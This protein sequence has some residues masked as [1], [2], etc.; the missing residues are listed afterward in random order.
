MRDWTAIILAAGKGTRMVSETPKVLHRILG[1]SLIS[2]PLGLA[3]AL[4]CRKI[5]AVVGHGIDAVKEEVCGLDKNKKVSFAI[6]AEQRGTGHAVMCALET[7]AETSGS[8][9]ILSG[10]VPMLDEASVT[11]LENAFRKSGRCALLSF[12]P[13][14][15]TGYGRI[16]RENGRPRAIREHRDCS[17][18]EHKIREVNAG[19]YLVDMAFLRT[20]VQNLKAD[21]NQAELYL[22]DI[23]AEAAKTDSLEAVPVDARL[24]AGINDRSE[25]CEMERVMSLK[26]NVTLMKSGVT[27][28]QPESIRIE[29]DVTVAK[30]TE[31]YG[32]VHL[33]GATTVG[34]RCIIG[35]GSALHNCTL[36]ERVTVKPYTVGEGASLAAGCEVGPMARLRPGAVIGENAHIGNWV[37]VKN[38]TVGRG[39]KANHLAYLGDGI[40][41]DGVN[42]GAGTIFCNYDGFQKHK[43]VL[44]NGVFIGSDS[45]LVAPVTVGE[46]AYVASGSTITRDVPPDDLALSRVKQ[47][48]KTGRAAMLKKRLKAEKE[49]R[50]TEAKK[51][52]EGM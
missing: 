14:D 1:R 23:A 27:M 26:R 44:G 7:I 38:T 51:K 42:I 35:Q 37:E 48:N 30:D 18:T 39:S 31:I 32:G 34:E 41:G 3:D 47:E 43:T 11:A 2:F 52:E 21:N 12:V 28:H 46:G 9:L 40:I 6:Q 45:Q 33:S 49:R 50:L 5:V 22:T 8:V 24:V 29:W 25:L 36:A 17:D 13:E 20:A 19:V 15:P 4:G 16:I 10:D